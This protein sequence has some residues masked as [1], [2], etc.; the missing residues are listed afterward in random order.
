VSLL[1]AARPL[2]FDPSAVVVD[3]RTDPPLIRGPHVRS[4]IELESG[5]GQVAPQGRWSEADQF[6][7]I[8]TVPAGGQ[9][10]LFIEGRVDRNQ[11]GGSTLAVAVNGRHAGEVQLSRAMT[12]QL[13]EV[14]GAPLVAGRNRIQFRLSDP[15][16]GAAG[17]N[18]T[19]L[20]RRLAVSLDDSQGF[21]AALRRE[22]VRVVSDRESVVVR[23]EGQLALPFEVPASGSILKFRYR[24][25]NPLPG[26]GAQVV[27]ARRY[28]D[29]ARFDVA[30]SLVLDADDRRFGRIRHVL[31]DRG[32]PS[33]L[34]IRVN[35]AAARG[36]FVIE[37]PRVVVRPAES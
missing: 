4:T 27:V 37:E 11:A 26:A 35:A 16:S 9:S 12:R 23:V 7:V 36:G 20:V 10:A 13:I 2:T 1:D 6:E 25:R 30:R 31:R 32:E 28:G 33:A 24:F 18:R 21:P 17:A 8:W 5:W 29:P 22:P 3:L 14:S 19:A 15:L 34:L